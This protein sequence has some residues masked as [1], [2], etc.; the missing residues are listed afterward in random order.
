MCNE[1]GHL[2]SGKNHRKAFCAKIQMLMICSEMH[3]SGLYD[4]AVPL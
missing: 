1:A 4:M 3:V 2:S